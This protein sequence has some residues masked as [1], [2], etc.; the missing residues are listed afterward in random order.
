MVTECVESALVELY[1]EAGG[2]AT[3]VALASVGSLARQELGPRSDIDLVLLHD[4]RS[5]R[6][7]DQLAN[8]LWYPLWDA[9]IHIDHS[10]RTVPEALQVAGEDISAGL[11]MLDARHIAMYVCRQLTNP[12]P[13]NGCYL[14][15]PILATIVRYRS[16]SF[17]L[18]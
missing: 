15:R 9:N 11:A 14:R 2:P 17:F 8:R 18:T 13:V 7:I 16:T 5:A 10:V 6:R 1:A 4:G 12:P 3:G